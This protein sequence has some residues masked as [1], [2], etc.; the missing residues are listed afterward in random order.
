M[1]R[2]YGKFSGRYANSEDMIAFVSAAFAYKH[3]SQ[4]WNTLGGRVKIE[5]YSGSRNFMYDIYFPLKRKSVTT[6]YGVLDVWK[7]TVLIV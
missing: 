2:S 4:R 3:E 7:S 1:M 5:V 6:T